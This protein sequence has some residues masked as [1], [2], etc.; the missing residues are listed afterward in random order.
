MKLGFS[1]FSLAVVLFTSCSYLPLQSGSKDCGFT[2]SFTLPKQGEGPLILFSRV[3]A[4]ELN[5]QTNCGFAS[6]P[7]K[8]DKAS[9]DGK[10]LR[11]VTI[12]ED[13]VYAAPAGFDPTTQAIS[14]EADGRSYF[15]NQN[16]VR[17]DGN[18]YL[19]GLRSFPPK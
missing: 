4:E 6:V 8:V 3:L 7:T 5:G 2:A 11:V 15:T 18:R 16:E 13:V 12:G 10:E 14:I 19:I 9:V 1:V 17:R